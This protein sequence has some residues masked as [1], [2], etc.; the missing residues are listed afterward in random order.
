MIKIHEFAYNLEI[1]KIL[2]NQRIFVAVC[3][4]EVCACVCEWFKYSTWISCNLAIHAMIMKNPEILN[5]YS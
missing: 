3:V 1:Q 4:D 5:P 2:E